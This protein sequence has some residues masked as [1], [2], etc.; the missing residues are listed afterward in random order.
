MA[1]ITL[2]HMTEEKRLKV[3]FFLSNVTRE[4]SA[5]ERGVDCGDDRNVSAANVVSHVWEM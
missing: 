5:L 3:F 2:V 1:F 4:R